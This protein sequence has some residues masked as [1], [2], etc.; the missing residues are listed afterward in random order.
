MDSSLNSVLI[1][2]VNGK[3][4]VENEVNPEWT[5]LY[6]LRNKLLLCGTKLGCGEG[7]CGACTVMVS[8]Y[9]RKLQKVSHLA[10]N[11]CLAPI[12]SMHGLAVTT[13]EGIGSTKTKLHPVQERIA[14]AHGSQC[15]FCTPGIVMS[16]YTLLR[17]SPKP[18]M[19]DLE[20]TFQGNLCRCTGY[21]PILDGFKTFTEEWEAIQNEN[22]IS[23]CNGVCS[24]SDQCCKLQNGY[25]ETEK[26]HKDT[27]FEPSEF[28]PFDST[29]EPIFPPELKLNDALDKQFLIFK[30]NEVTWFR[31]TK[32]D[33]IL[34]LKKTYPDA[35][36]I[37][38]NTEVGIEV[39]FKNCNYPVRI[40]PVLIDEMT[41]VAVQENKIRVGASVTLEN[42]IAF[43]K[44]EINT[45]PKY[46]TRIL[47]SIIKMLN[48][49]AGRQI[50]NVAAVGGNIMTG[51]P[52]SDLNQIFIAA[53]V[54]LELHS[55]NNGSRKILM[56]ET[57]FTSYRQNIVRKDEVLIA[58]YIPYTTKDQYFYS[59]KQA[60]RRDDDTAIVNSAINVTFKPKS[61]IISN[62]KMAFG[63][64]GPTTIV[65]IKTCQAIKNQ[66]WN[67][68]TLNKIYKCLIED[69]PLLPGAP[70]GMTQ[71]RK[72][73]ALSFVFKAFL[74]ISQE[75]QNYTQTLSINEIQLS[76]LTEF[77]NQIPKG[78]QYYEIL[79]SKET[80]H[81][82]GKPIPHLSAFKHATGEAIYCDDIPPFANELYMTLVISQ[83]AHAKFQL[84]PSEAL[85]MDGV[86]LFVSADDIPED[87]NYLEGP[88][89][90]IIFARDIV[91]S[92]GQILGAVIAENQLIAQKAARKVKV[93]YQNLYPLI[94]TTEDAITHNSYF[95]KPYLLE[96]GDVDNVF[97]TAPHVIEKEC[98][99]G[100]Q[101]HFYLETQ[102]VV[103][104]PKHEDGEM[105]IYCSTQQPAKISSAVASILGVSESRITARTKRLGGAF[106]GKEMQPLYVAAPAAMAASKLGRP[107]RCMLE[108]DDDM[109]VTGK[110]HPLYA[111]YKCA[112]DSNGKILACEMNF[113]LN[114]GYANNQ[115]G[116]VLMQTMFKFENAYKIPNVRVV[117]YLCKTNLPSNN[118]LRAFGAPQG[119]FIMEM[120]IRQIGEHL[121]K[122]TIEVANINF[123][124]EGDTTFYNQKLDNVT[125]ER[126]WSE[127][128][129]SSSFFERSK[130]IDIYNRGNRWKKRGISLVPLKYAIG[131][132]VKQFNQAAALLH[133]YTDGSVLLSHGGVEMG[134][135]LHTKMVQIAAQALQIPPDNIFISETSTDKVPNAPPT[136]ASMSSDFSGKAVQ[137]A[138]DKLIKR[139]EPFKNANPKGK[140][141]NW[142]LDAY[143]NRVSLSAT[144]FYKPPFNSYNFDLHT[145]SPYNYYSYGT[146]CSEV[147]I[148]CLTGDHQLLRTDIVMDVGCSL[149]PAIDIGQIEGAFIQGYGFYMIEEFMYSPDGLMLTKGPGTYK[150]PGFGNVPHEFNVSLLKDA[151][152][153]KAIHSSKAIGEP[154]LCLATSTL[155]ATREAIKAA[156]VDYGLDNT[157]LRIDAPLTSEKIRM[158]CEDHLTSMFKAAEPETYKPW[159]VVV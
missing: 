40:H 120:M 134:Q 72:S 130:Q 16:M 99:S 109:M 37:V 97:A 135:G 132:G 1:F 145:G 83:R 115:S 76:A 117:G 96:N 18:S 5:L 90:E 74:A 150:L 79:S 30:N 36:I 45:Q 50:R 22:L 47:T 102:S 147:E 136:V 73:L 41:T 89:S 81:C 159:N 91:T 77:S 151:P 62:I 140:W 156:R 116:A 128:I 92:Q 48:W 64:M 122:S 4:I 107:V 82:V 144:G 67:E 129:D 112:F 80:I 158:A 138:C 65:P 157:N 127:C 93:N 26:E 131:V 119:I 59:Y 39:K 95:G 143:M 148:D 35:K 70:G 27:L 31:P 137:I 66:P 78:S 44:E 88:D 13:V 17:C 101:A 141:E 125:L 46:K 155:F 34:D 100:A 52:I 68:E 154:P 7:G 86:K 153:P 28:V 110:R 15:G 12:C 126:C 139:L 146:A 2:F 9:N 32:L 57:F 63:G 10:I 24:M 14:K 42:M 106:G 11:A 123:F 58:I 142:V 51:S 71:Y 105:E 108:R 19:Q 87:K 111:K 149:N 25:N 56:D 121:K 43:L 133:V 85:C 8:K 38:G 104:L 55:K 84:D 6:Y 103:A 60:R 69:L 98:R 21:R 61:N 94:I 54:E 124:K 33:D 49:F 23:N 53:K 20:T 75:L 113:Y 152:N 114:V 3:K 29:Q 118:A